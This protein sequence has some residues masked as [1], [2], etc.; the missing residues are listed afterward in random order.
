[1]LLSVTLTVLAVWLA[2]V[3]FFDPDGFRGQR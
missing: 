1:M 3:W 2:F